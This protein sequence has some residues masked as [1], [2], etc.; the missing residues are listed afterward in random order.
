LLE[1]GLHE[2]LVERGIEVAGSSR[3]ELKPEEASGDPIVDLGRHG[4]KLGAEIARAIDSGARAFVAG[5]TCNHV[6]GILAGL[7]AAYGS[8]SRIGIVWFDAHGDCNTPSTSV[9]GMTWG[10]PLGVALGLSYPQWR[11]GAGM[12]APIPT[13]RVV[14][15]DIRKLD[16]WEAGF[17]GAS[18][19][20]VSQLVDGRPGPRA[21]DAIAELA[22]RV[23]HLYVHID[24]DVLD[25]PFVPNLVFAEP[26]GP[27]VE[28]TAQAVRAAMATGKVR[29]YGVVSFDPTGP[30]GE[31]SLRSAMTLIQEGVSDWAASPIQD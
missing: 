14:F 12:T 5:G 9:S 30:G 8:A 2:S 3:V 25:R 1:A 22:K 6:S 28:R 24:T 26:G 7:Q 17:I 19:A 11:E 31:I 16:P 15:V 20:V 10:M 23:D 13:N 21:E 29:A 4:A 18:D 27:D